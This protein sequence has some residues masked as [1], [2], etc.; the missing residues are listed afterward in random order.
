MSMPL[1]GLISKE[2]G[3]KSINCHENVQIQVVSYHAGLLLLLLM[4]PINFG[5]IFDKLG[6][7]KKKNQTTELHSRKKGCRFAPF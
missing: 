7:K 2:E 1:Q 5:P 6:C 3:V 4:A